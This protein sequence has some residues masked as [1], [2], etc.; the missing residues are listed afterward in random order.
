MSLTDDTPGPVRSIECF[1]GRKV[2]GASEGG[3]I[4][5]R[6]ERKYIKSLIKMV[7]PLLPLHQTVLCLLGIC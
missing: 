6:R 7:V 5:G 2:G 1:L 3:R 4:E